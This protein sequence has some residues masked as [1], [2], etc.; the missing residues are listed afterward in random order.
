MKLTLPKAVMIV[1]L[2][3]GLLLASA[4]PAIARG[5]RTVVAKER[6]KAAEPAMISNV[7]V[8]DGTRRVTLKIKS[9]TVESVDPITISY[10]CHEYGKW[11]QTADPKALPARLSI[12]LPEGASDCVVS[13]GI[14]GDATRTG[15]LTVKV[16]AR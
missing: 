5:D 16:F 15:R 2:A 10:A 7:A 3:A 14:T 1:L 8:P 9:K 13:A 4:A 12:R 11:K 6:F